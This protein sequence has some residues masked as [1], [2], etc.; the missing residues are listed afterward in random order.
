MFCFSCDNK[1]NSENI[2]LSDSIAKQTPRKTWDDYQRTKDSLWTVFNESTDEAEVD[3]ARVML[4]DMGCNADWGNIVAKD[5]ERR[6]ARVEKEFQQLISAHP[7]QE[8]LFIEE[9]ERWEKYHEAVL[10]VAKLEDHGSSGGS[11]FCSTGQAETDKNGEAIVFGIILEEP[12]GNFYD[13]KRLLIV[14]SS[15]LLAVFPLAAQRKAAFD[16]DFTRNSVRAEYGALIPVGTVSN[17]GSGLMSL[18][19]TRRFSGH[20]GWRTGVQ[21]APVDTRSLDCSIGRFHQ[22]AFYL[23]DVLDLD[24]LPV[25]LYGAGKA[26]PKHGRVLHRGPVYMEIDKRISRNEMESLGDTHRAQASCMRKYYISRYQSIA[27]RFER[28]L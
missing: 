23:A 14:F 24:I 26:L 8:G 19:Y 4:Y 3:K 28:T 9:K 16:P 17:S 18:S 6:K 11:T 13:M 7:E 2:I 25:I 10:A 1:S 22:G 27:D 21:Y 12:V 5:Y 15:I 20:W